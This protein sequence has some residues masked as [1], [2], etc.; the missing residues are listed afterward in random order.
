LADAV[1]RENEELLRKKKPGRIEAKFVGTSQVVRSALAAHL[2][3]VQ[4]W[5]KLVSLSD[6]PA[7]KSVHKIFVEL[8]TYLMPLS[9]HT[10]AAEREN[11]EQLLPALIRSNRHSA[12]LGQPGAGKTTSLQKICTDY[13]NTGKA[14]L[15]HSFPLLVRLRDISNSTSEHPIIHRIQE[16]LGIAVTFPSTLRE[17]EQAGVYDLVVTET[18]VKYVDELGAL[19]L[20]DGFDEIAAEEARNAALSDIQLL[21]IKLKK[22]RLLITS[23]S[24]EF[25]YKLSEIQ[26]FELAPLTNSQ[27][28]KFA[29]RWLDGPAAAKDFLKKVNASP[30]ADSAIRPLTIAHLCAIYERIKRL[31]DKPKSVYRKIVNLLLEEWDSQRNVSRVSKYAEFDSDRKLEFLAH[32]SFMLTVRGK[33]VF[34]TNTLKTVYSKIHAEYGL[35]TNQ[36]AKVIEEIES[37]SGLIVEGGY[38]AYEFAHKSLQEFLAADYLVRLHSAKVIE[39]YAQRLPNELAIA[40]ALSSRPAAYMCDVALRVAPFAYLSADWYSIYLS[41]LTLE[42]PDLYPTDP[43]ENALGALTLLT[44]SGSPSSYIELV[45]PIIPKNISK[46]IEKYYARGNVQDDIRMLRRVKPHPTCRLPDTLWMPISIE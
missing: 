22:S 35:P 2:E 32:V 23:R 7:Q 12:I 37:H 30:F 5:S 6:S 46:L 25:R 9:T 43:L 20:L 42:K 27:I 33:A 11:T 17:A 3:D 40:T 31:P 19:L 14:L 44:Y 28:E 38:R 16:I 26:K 10:S 21:S 1:R 34:D 13:F 45:R 4:R 15:N 39:E 29:E 41:R 18:V 8:D 36:A 24:R